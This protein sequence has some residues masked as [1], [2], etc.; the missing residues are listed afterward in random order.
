[1]V[2]RRYQIWVGIICGLITAQVVASVW[3][4][5]SYQLSVAT[6]L[7]Q[8][9]LLIA[10]VILLAPNLSRTKNRTPRTKV[11]WLLMM[12]GVGL[13]LSYQLLWTYFEVV[14]QK[15]VPDIFVGDIVLFLHLVP[16]TAA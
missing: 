2:S 11:F 7:I 9:I 15:D 6:D 3:L 16:M 4:P 8:C 14:L 10:A 13:W 5:P 1:M 12:T